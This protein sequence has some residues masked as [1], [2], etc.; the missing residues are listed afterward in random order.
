MYG[1]SM[2]PAKLTLRV[3]KQNGTEAELRQSWLNVPLPGPGL[4]LGTFSGYFVAAV[5]SCA[6]AAAG[7]P[8]ISIAH[9]AAGRMYI[10][11]RNFPFTS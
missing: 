8:F 2:L 6:S 1:C 5:A 11:A 4:D 7:G 3:A 10:D 9:I